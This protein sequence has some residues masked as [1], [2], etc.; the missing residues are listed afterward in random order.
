MRLLSQFEFT[1]EVENP[2]EALALAITRGLDNV[3]Y[4]QAPL[5]MSAGL[6]TALVR[7]VGISL[8]E[9]DR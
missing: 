9:E 1:A 7:G 8:T 3:A 4:A 6:D 5:G 2:Q